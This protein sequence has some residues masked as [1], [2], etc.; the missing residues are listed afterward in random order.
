MQLDLSL[1]VVV[2]HQRELELA[3]KIR[4]GTEAERATAIDELVNSHIAFAHLMVHQRSPRMNRSVR[5]VTVTP[6]LAC[7]VRPSNTILTVR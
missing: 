6:C 4:S 5:S 3:A 7:T 2:D 1:E